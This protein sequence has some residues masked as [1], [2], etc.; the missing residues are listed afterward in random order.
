MN[1]P[2]SFFHE[3]KSFLPVTLSCTELGKLSSLF[4]ETLSSLAHN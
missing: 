1:K 3:P 2:V 4:H